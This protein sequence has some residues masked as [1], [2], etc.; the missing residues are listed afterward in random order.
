MRWAHGFWIVWITAMLCATAAT[1]QGEKSPAE[2]EKQVAELI[3][4]YRASKDKPPVKLD[5]RLS[6]VCRSYCQERV[7]GKEDDPLRDVSGVADRFEATK[8]PHGM[9][10]ELKQKVEP[11]DDPAAVAVAGWLDE[12]AERKVG[13]FHT[14]AQHIA[15]SYCDILGVGVAR[16]PAGKYFFSIML[17]QELP[18]PAA[19]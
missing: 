3:N 1:A 9:A 6:T 5:E 18:E 15:N 4:Q 2:M 10:V 11:C 8:V 16:S 19:Q 13:I 12:D 14:S 7:A 17:F